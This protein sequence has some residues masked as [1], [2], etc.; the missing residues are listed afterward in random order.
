MIAGGTDTTTVTVTWAIALLL[1]HR[2]VLRKAQEELDGV[3]SKERALTEGD[4]GKLI[5]LQSIVKETMRMYPPAPL[6]AVREFVRD[7][8]VAGYRVRKG[9]WLMVNAWKIQNDPSM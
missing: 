4:I 8:D 1:N 2:H 3:V 5:Y 7:C 6:L 9:T